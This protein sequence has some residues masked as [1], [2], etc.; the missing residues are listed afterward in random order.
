MLS[1]VLALPEPSSPACW[2]RRLWCALLRR[3]NAPSRAREANTETRPSTTRARSGLTETTSDRSAASRECGCCTGTSAVR[4]SGSACVSACL[5]LH[6]CIDCPSRTPLRLPRLLRNRCFCTFWWT[7]K[8]AEKWTCVDNFVADWLLP[9]AGIF[10]E[11]HV[12]SKQSST[13]HGQ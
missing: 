4:E 10:L 9:R 12:E 8:A 1:M 5:S 6:R 13:K 2:L 3:A 7:H 11:S